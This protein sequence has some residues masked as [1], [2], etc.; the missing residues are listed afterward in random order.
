M[1]DFHDEPLNPAGEYV[2][3]PSRYLAAILLAGHVSV[4]AVLLV[5]DLSLLWKSAALVFLLV[6]LAYELR[7]AWRV[8]ANAV[9]GFRVSIDGTP[10]IFTRRD[11]WRDCEVLGSTYVTA[12]LTV[13]NLRA[14]GGRRIRSVVILPDCMV[15]DDYRR[16]RVWLRWRPQAEGN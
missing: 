3:G 4:A 2:L 1:N 15:A 7:M 8:G 12:F 10:G 9:T 14:S 16:L 6:S 13:V 11:G 5:V